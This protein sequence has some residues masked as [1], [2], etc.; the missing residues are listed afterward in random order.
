MA[1]AALQMLERAANQLL[2]VVAPGASRLVHT[3]VTLENAA[4]TASTDGASTI[5]MP[6]SF[7]GQDIPANE[8]VSVGLLAHELGHFLQP[9]KAVVEVAKEEGAPKWL[10]NVLLD[11]Q[12]EALVESLFPAVAAPLASVRACVKHEKLRSYRKALA[13]ATSFAEAAGPLALLGRFA[14]GDKPFSDQDAQDALLP[15]F[16]AVGRRY[17]NLLKKAED[18]A[19]DEL[20]G[21]LRS[22]M[23]ECPELRQAQ[24]PSSPLGDP[25]A[26][27]NGALGDLLAEEARTTLRGWSRSP[28]SALQVRRY[29]R[30]TPRREAER[31]AHAIRTRFDVR[32]GGMEVLAPGRFDRQEAARGNLPFRMA[33]MGCERPLPRVVICVDVSSSMDERRKAETAFTAAQAL[34]LAVEASGGEVVGLL[35][36]SCAGVSRAGDASAIFA[37]RGQWRMVDGTNFLFLTEAWRRWPRHRFLLVTDGQGTAPFALPA[38]RDRTAAIVV[39]PGS[40]AALQP[41]CGRIVELNR[42]D[43]LP[44]LL[45]LLLPRSD[46]A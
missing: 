9:L 44:S 12:G 43:L 18:L 23:R 5:T 34:A 42:L 33:V 14:E 29:T 37:L 15:A 26:Q 40:S 39:P 17:L 46:L 20:P 45:A 2:A 10:V 13:K 28:K 4:P 11:I 6:T 27:L 8:A 25:R 19:P 22:L 35:F 16:E 24:A 36:D 32:Q 30:E 41:I 1:D 38:D 21:H 3:Q 7:C 31:L